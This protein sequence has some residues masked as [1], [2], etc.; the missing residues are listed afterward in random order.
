[1]YTLYFS[2]GT[3]SLAV[4]LALLE[5]GADYRLEKVDIETGAQRDPRYLQLNPNGVVPTLLIEGKPFYESASLLMTIADRHPQAGLA[6]AADSLE[7]AA[8][9]QWI[10]HLSNTVQVAFRLWFYPHEIDA[11]P[12]VQALTKAAAQSRIE[13]AWSRFDTQLRANGPYLMGEKFSAADL[14]LLMLMRWSRNMPKPATEWPALREFAAKLKARPSWARLY[15]IE[16]L[17]EWA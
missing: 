8:W 14:M 1:M 5:V 6:P 3:A 4:H 2:P 10:M 11:A 12:E 17:T 13:A 7:R 15:E 9:N 16:G